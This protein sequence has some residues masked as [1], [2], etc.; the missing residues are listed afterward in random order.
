MEAYSKQE[1]LVIIN[2]EG[3]FPPYEMRNA[4]GELQGFYIELVEI[5]S[6]QINVQVQYKTLPWRRGLYAMGQ[7][8]ADAMLSVTKTPERE[9]YLWFLKGNALTRVVDAFC[10]RHD[11]NLAHTFRG[12]LRQLSTS[13]IGLVNGYDY[14]K[15]IEDSSFLMK[16]YFAKDNHHLLRLLLRGRVDIIMA[17]RN[18]ALH[19]A[20][21]QGIRDKIKC[22]KPTYNGGVE[23]L[24]F[25]KVRNN[26]KVAKR[27]SSALVEFKNTQDYLDLAK[28]HNITFDT[29][30]S[31]NTNSETNNPNTPND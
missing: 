25:S 5:I 26:L 27:F 21:D 9:R 19:L 29:K 7:G 11:H 1:K 14:A 20:N 22:L 17:D 12:D 4:Y 16:K 6:K 30:F 28:E 2:T 31:N 13:P 3:N 24:A 23:Y 10:V 8:K 18:V 15:E